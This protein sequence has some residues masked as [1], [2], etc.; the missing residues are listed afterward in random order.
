MAKILI[1]TP[2]LDMFEWDESHAE[3]LF[4][5]NSNPEVMRYTGNSTFHS[6]EEAKNLI[7]NYDQYK[8]HGFGRWLC[9]LR[10]TGE[11]IGWCGL[12]RHKEEEDEFIDLGYRFFKEHWG[13][14][15][16]TESAF[17]VLQ[18]GFEKL[19]IDEILA[20][21]VKKNVAS[22]KVIEKLGMT[23][24]KGADCHDLPAEY[25]RLA[26][27]EFIGNFSG[28]SALFKVEFPS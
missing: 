11:I 18:Y 3:V 22:I 1:R 6:L 7:A 17:A 23:Y 10:T 27:E 24:W 5:M 28:D 26:R 2:R 9:A 21:S 16:A 12:K 14:G 25:Y 8:K 20:R 15:Y 13:M 19:Q 4:E